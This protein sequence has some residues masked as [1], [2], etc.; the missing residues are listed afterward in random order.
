MHYGRGTEDED[1][2]APGYWPLATVGIA[3]FAT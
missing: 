2:L 1:G 3:S